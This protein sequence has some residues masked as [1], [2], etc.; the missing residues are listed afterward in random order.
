MNSKTN[1]KN[2]RPAPRK[3]T[4]R[5]S[6][7][8]N[9]PSSKKKSGKSSMVNRTQESTNL[10]KTSFKIFIGCIP[11]NAKEEEVRK[12][13]SAYEPHITHLHLERRKNNKCSGYGHL[14]V[15]SERVYRAVLGAKHTL[16]HRNLSVLPFLE[17]HDLIQSQLKFNKRRIVVAQLPHEVTDRQLVEHF[18]RFG[19][20]EKGFVV[21]NVKDQDLL[22]YGHIIFRTEE[23]ALKARKTEHFLLGK[24]VFVKTHK[25]DVKKKLQ[26]RQKVGM[27]L[28]II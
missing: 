14:Q 8:S 3:T 6:L 20:I 2:E 12:V 10:E 21:K 9:H 7:A 4:P 16:G 15:S 17:K 5:A 11:G 18:K 25:I 22:P 26:E 23:A 28:F 27:A 13:F 19:D 1:F 24:R